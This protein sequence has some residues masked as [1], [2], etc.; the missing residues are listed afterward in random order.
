MDTGPKRAQTAAGSPVWRGLALA[1]AL[2]AVLSLLAGFAGARIAALAAPSVERRALDAALALVW[3]GSAS[4][5]VGRGRRRIAQE[6]DGRL[7]DERRAWNLGVNLFAALGY[8]YV[9]LVA[10]ALVRVDLSGI[11]VGGAVTGIVIG[12][13][14]QSAL[15][16]LFGGMLVLLLHP[17]S[18]GQRIMVRSG[19]FGGV[20]YTG[21]VREVTL[22]YTI[23]D[24]TGGRL[25]IPNA[26]AVASVVRVEP[27]DSQESVL[28]PLPYTI[29]LD[30]L[31]TALRSQGV[32]DA[33]RVEAYGADAYSVRVRLP[34]G[35][36]D[37]ALVAALRS[38]RTPPP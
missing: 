36:G 32:P 1:L 13:A 18:A 17:Y 19:S 6:R 15:G 10:L 16:N 12:I 34:A 5:V 14:A 30:Q 35:D 29:G 25:V 28:L 3:L 2:L 26:L 24:A 23:L 4:I 22:F 20:E 9:L 11:L 31:R 38:L 37:G 27:A 21:T 8:A 7:A 33:V